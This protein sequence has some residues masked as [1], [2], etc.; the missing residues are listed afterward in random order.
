MENNQEKKKRVQVE[1]TEEDE[2]AIVELLVKRHPEFRGMKRLLV[3]SVA[4]R[5]RPD[6]I[7]VTG[8]RILLDADPD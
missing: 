5:Y 3:R 8:D 7:S 2:Q 4:Q 6:C 1:F